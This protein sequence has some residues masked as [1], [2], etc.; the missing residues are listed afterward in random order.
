MAAG[1]IML[2]YTDGL[3][4]HHN[5]NEESYF[6]TVETTLKK[7]KQLPAQEIFNNI[8]EDIRGFSPPTDD[9]SYIVIKK[10]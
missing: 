10:N 4:E 2:L 5:K 6:E 7:I 8:M 1:D 3:S 9:V